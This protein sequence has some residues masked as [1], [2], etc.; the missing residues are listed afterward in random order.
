VT[1]VVVDVDGALRAWINAM[2][3]LVGNGNPLANGV[4][5]GARSPS[6]GSWAELR[7]P[8]TRQLS[9][10]ADQPRVALAVKAAGSKVDG[11][12][13][14]LAERA[15]R[16]LAKAI[17][18][19]YGIG[20]VTTARGELVKLISVTD[21]QGPVYAGEEGGEQTFLVDFIVTAQP[22]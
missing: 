14:A 13:Y 8:T 7:G 2:T 1:V 16:S 21:L 4:H 22:G 9:D 12:A 5:H 20:T 19:Q 3:S 18:D 6:Q 10:V 11:G 17:G 15:A